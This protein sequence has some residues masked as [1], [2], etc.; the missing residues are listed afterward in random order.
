[1]IFTFTLL[2]AEYNVAIHLDKAAVAIPGEAFVAG[3]LDEGDDRLIVETKIENRI[4]HTGHG[5][6]GTRANRH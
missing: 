2:Y 6:A 5:I 4:H 3:S 1:M